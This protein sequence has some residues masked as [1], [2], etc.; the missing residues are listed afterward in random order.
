MA[1][2][3]G[4]ID[5]YTWGIENAS[6]DIAPGSVITGAKLT[7]HNAAFDPAST[8]K[9]ASVHLLNN[10]LA[11]MTSYTDGQA[12]DFFASRGAL[13]AELKTGSLTTSPQ[14]V[15]IDL[16]LKND[17]A[18]SIWKNFGQPFEVTL[19]G[20]SKVAYS[21]A[22]V[23]LLD[24]AGSGRS[25]GF[26]I[27]CD[28]FT[29][30]NLSLELTVASM[31]VVQPAQTLRFSTSANT[32]PT[33]SPIAGQTLKVG[34]PLQLTVSA[35]DTEGDPLVYSASGLPAGATFNNRVFSWTP[36]AGQ[37]GTHQ[38]TF[39]V[40]DGM[41]SDNLTV[42]F[43]VE[44]VS[45]QVDIIID[46]RD[47]EVSIVGTWP[48]SGG[49]NPYETDAVYCRD[50]NRSFSWLF[51]A[52][53]TGTYEV[54]M[55]WT[56]FSSR[57][58]VTPVRVQH[59][60]GTAAMTVNQQTN[61]GQ[62]NTMGTYQYQAGTTY[63]VTVLTLADRSSICADAVRFVKTAAPQLPS[64][65]IIDNRDPEVSIVGTWPV[66]GGVDPYE[67]DAVYCREANRS[68]SWLFTAPQTGSYEV[69]MWWTEFSSRSSVTPVQVTH[70]SGTASMTVDQK[71]N[72]GR[73]NTLGTYQFQAGTT[74]RVTLL[75]LADRSSICA[76]AVRFIKK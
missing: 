27:G 3:Y 11:D 53:E 22:M 19:A 33:L 45:T 44:N 43:T 34:Q 5:A 60:S 13:L 66:S 26:G 70:A 73:W 17:P 46:N 65:V 24:Y 41:A 62:W 50:A 6:L 20:G 23:A 39:T 35:A 52:P 69:S 38:V 14:N 59:A 71:T 28:G 29:F 15:V 12:G 68:F 48:V 57:S 7:I 18:A 2:A 63:R 75:T 10:P 16:A 56:A 25:F 55:W 72:G 31:T 40:S 54:S 32:P 8:V 30:T 36:A 21:S 67:A 74:Y 47:P 64:E 51:T 4:P 49:V 58:S 42:S 61:G 1:A 9:A 37:V 76:D